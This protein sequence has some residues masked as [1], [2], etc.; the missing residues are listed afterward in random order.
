MG[1]TS[2]APSS[3]LRT[4]RTAELGHG[5]LIAIIYVFHGGLDVIILRISSK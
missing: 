4:Q 1:A 3:Q 2:L 5:S